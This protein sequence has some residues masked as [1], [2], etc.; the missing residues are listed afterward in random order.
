MKNLYIVIYPSTPIVWIYH[1]CLSN[2][3][4]VLECK[5]ILYVYYRT[6]SQLH[7]C[8]SRTILIYLLKN[9]IIKNLNDEKSKGSYICDQRSFDFFPQFSKIIRH[10]PAVNM[11]DAGT[12]YPFN[13]TTTLPNL[14][15]YNI[16]GRTNNNYLLFKDIF[17]K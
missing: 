10:K 4:M 3:L 13:T 12:R 6:T 11:S 9:M 5:R 2:V 15:I 16:N 17:T 7:V 14:I 8:N 1:P